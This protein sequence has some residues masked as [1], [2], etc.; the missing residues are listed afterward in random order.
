MLCRMMTARMLQ[1]AV[2]NSIRNQDPFLQQKI[3]LEIAAETQ[4]LRS[5]PDIPSDATKVG[6]GVRLR[7]GPSK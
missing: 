7:C 2:E 5:Q 3:P 6:L 4:Q 1:T